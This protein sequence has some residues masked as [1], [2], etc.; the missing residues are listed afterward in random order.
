MRA[1]RTVVLAERFQ[2]YI[3]V[4]YDDGHVEL[5]FEDMQSYL[6]QKREKKGYRN[7]IVLHENWLYPTMNQKDFSCH[8]VNLYCLNQ[9]NS[10]YQ[11]LLEDKSLYQKA[12]IM[13]MKQIQK[14]INTFRIKEL[15]VKL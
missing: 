6:Q 15:K 12:K 13:Y 11:F 2:R 1:N 10:Y 7:A 5:L 14:E 8:W 4:Y 3:R 9:H